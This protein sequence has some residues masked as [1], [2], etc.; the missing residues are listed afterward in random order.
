MA[1]MPSGFCSGYK[2]F[3]KEGAHEYR[4]EKLDLKARHHSFEFRAVY[5]TIQD[6]MQRPNVIIRSVYSNFSPLGIFYLGPYPIDLVIVTASGQILMYQFDGMWCHGCQECPPIGRYVNGQTW[7]QVREKTEK[8]DANTLEWI[9][10][11]NEAALQCQLSA[12]PFISYHVIQDCCTPGYSPQTLRRAFATEPALTKLIKGYSITDMCG[13]STS[14]ST[15]QHLLSSITDSSYTFIAYANVI[16]QAID[17]EQ[18]SLITYET[19]ENRY[20]RQHLSHQGHVVLT[21]N[22]Y[23]WLQATFG[24]RLEITSIEWILFYATDPHWNTIYTHLTQLRSSTDDKVMVTFLKRIVNLSCG[25]FGARTSSLDKCSYRLV[26]SLPANYAFYL[27]FPDMNYTMDIGN[28]SYFLLE[29]KPRPKLGTKRKATSSALPMFITIIEYGK[30][31]LV[32]ILH[33]IQQHV[34]PNSFKLLYSNVDNLIYALA[35][36]DTLEEAVRPECQIN[37]QHNKESYFALDKKQPGLAE[38]KWI[39]NGNV[40]WK[41]LTMRTQ[42]YCIVI[43]EQEHKTNLHK[44]AGWS[45]LSSWEAYTSSKKLLEGEK[46]SLTQTRR[47]NKIANMDT[48]QIQYLY[49]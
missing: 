3:T 40:G 47:T 19:R 13:K 43:S 39:R 31:R 8:R 11:V 4:L 17:S 44:T 2:H 7:H 10:R 26:N 1:H 9:Q 23:Q 30:L 25:F 36:V 48:H 29:T 42:H 5:K 16:I 18:P 28:N 49:K 15:L 34:Y 6:V 22:Y 12:M 20:T 45:G 46:L 24:N 37:F 38:L 27:H 35:N 21:R 14:L 41:F 33:F 32:Q